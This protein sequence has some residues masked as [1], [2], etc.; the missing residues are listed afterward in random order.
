MKKPLVVSAF[1]LTSA[2]QNIIGVLRAKVLALLWGATHVGILGQILTLFNLQ[3]RLLTFGTTAALVNQLAREDESNHRDVVIQITFFIVFLTNLVTLT[4]FTVFAPQL[5]YLLFNTPKYSHF[6]LWMAVICPFFSLSR[7]LETLDQAEK[8][9]KRLVKGRIISMGLALILVIPLVYQL[10]VLGA[11]IDLLVWFSVSIIY[12]SPQRK[13]LLYILFRRSNK[14]NPIW[15]STIKICVADFSKHML[16]NASLAVFRILLVHELNLRYVGYFQALWSIVNYLNIF[17]NGFTIYFLPVISEHRSSTKTRQEISL[18]FT[19]LIYILV[20]VCA[21]L[22]LFPAPLLY[23]L[24]SKEFVQISSELNWMIFGKF[25]DLLFTF[26]IVIFLGQ[27][28]LRLFLGLELFRSISLLI[29]TYWLTIHF[30]FKG[31]IGGVVVVQIM[32]FLMGF[33]WI[34]KD[35][36]FALDRKSHLL[37]WRI[38]FMFIC[39]A[40][41]PGDTVFWVIGKILFVLI[42]VSIALNLKLYLKLIKEFKGRI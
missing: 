2:I 18:N 24:Y 4:I 42:F 11:I 1:V 21:F 23:L 8:K 39:L 27:R 25:F 22:L 31:A 15:K 40:L 37:L 10:G 33:Y 34:Q 41:F 13:E 35:P 32:S 9:F 38:V 36:L 12:F 14:L 20:P 5:S 26:F 19:M 6:I 16:F 7:L 28:Q 3:T 29:V 30:G 17:I